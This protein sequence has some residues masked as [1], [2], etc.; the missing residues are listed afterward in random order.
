MKRT[1]LDD[2]GA[3]LARLGLPRNHVVIVHSSLLTFGLI[4]GGLPGVMRVLNEVL[5]EQTTLLMPAFTFAYGASRVWDSRTTPAETGAL[6]EYFRKRPGVLR[7]LHPF[8][9]LSVSGPQAHAFASCKNLSSFGPGSPF[10]QLVEMEAVNLALGTEFVG[11]ATFLHHT[12]EVAAV[13]YR[14]YKEF[15]GQVLDAQGQAQADN[16]RMYVREITDA[17]EY[18]NDWAPVWD[19]FVSQ[20]LVRQQ[21]LAGA[22]IF[23][24]DIKP[25]HECLLHTL[26]AQPYYCAIKNIKERG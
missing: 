1:S 20:G 8:H 3:G 18:D 16:F 17:Y 5:G 10:E 4:E 2:L 7:T 13:P 9:S 19:L 6:T 22:N 24:I 23:A 12:E 21:N 15:P 26:Q 11:G 14:F 25:A